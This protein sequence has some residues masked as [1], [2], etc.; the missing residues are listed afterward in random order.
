MIFEI[1]QLILNDLFKKQDRLQLQKIL[2]KNFLM[3]KFN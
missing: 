2:S 3:G 1:T